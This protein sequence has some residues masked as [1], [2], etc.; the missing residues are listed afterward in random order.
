M[1]IENILKKYN[2]DDN[3][4]NRYMVELLSSIDPSSNKKYFSWLYNIFI[5]EA[6]TVNFIND[7][8]WDDLGVA[9]LRLENYPD[10][11]KNGGFSTDINSYKSSEDFI[12]TAEK[13]YQKSTKKVVLKND[14]DLV[15]EFNGIV[16][17]YP[18]TAEASCFYGRGTRWCITDEGTYYDYM[19]SGNLFFILNKSSNGKDYKTAIFIDLFNH[20]EVFNS[21]DTKLKATFDDVDEIFYSDFTNNITYPK[22]VSNSINK[23]IREMKITD[24]NKIK[25]KVFK[26]WVE[27]LGE[28]YV[29]GIGLIELSTFYLY[30][31]VKLYRKP[32][33]I[34]RYVV[35]DNSTLKEYKDE[36]EERAMDKFTYD[37]T[38]VKR[39]CYKLG[40]EKMLSYI[41]LDKLFEAIL[42][43]DD[44]FIFY[45]KYNVEDIDHYDGL[46]LTDELK[47]LKRDFLKNP[48]KF[49]DDN[50]YVDTEQGPPR[51][52]TYKGIESIVYNY[53]NEYDE[54]IDIERF[55][56]ENYLMM[57]DDMSSPIIW[58]YEGKEYYIIGEEISEIYGVY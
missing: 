9:L 41:N 12:F 31:G 50:I 32:M 5:K 19:E 36:N 13:A 45:D 43:D 55:Y 16:I 14:V 58:K 46:R 54:I 47:E 33:K 6:E 35:L 24:P 1:N 20:I 29:G 27:S 3:D 26:S 17:L 18:S 8:R 28:N 38:N 57:L 2:I 34:G 48:V 39:I 37:I 40:E 56:N 4:E 25:A 23:F 49:Y 22:R 53:F 21:E 44:K 7:V 30:G 11:F 52:T 51:F 42:K 10:R 15:D